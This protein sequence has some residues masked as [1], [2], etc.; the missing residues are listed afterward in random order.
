MPTTPLDEVDVFCTGGS[1]T[2]FV[3]SKLVTGYTGAENDP[4]F[5][6][7][8]NEYFNQLSA[9]IRQHAEIVNNEIIPNNDL[10]QDVKELAER[11]EF[12]TMVVF[13]YFGT[14]IPSGW[15]AFQGQVFD[16]TQAPKLFAANGNSNV[17]P[18]CR[19]NALYGAELLTGVKVYSLGEVKGHSHDPGTLSIDPVGNH[20]H[21]L[22]TASSGGSG[23]NGR[24]LGGGAGASTGGAGG[25]THTVSGGTGESGGPI[26]NIP[27]HVTCNF[28]TRFE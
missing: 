15:I 28:I 2:A 6:E 20:S 14:V 5:A 24:I 1:K 21:G 7:N 8:I 12:P 18:D 16:Q 13:P 11:N 26:G 27:R 19:E 17:L 25:H 10:F 23:D 9:A 22:Q 3:P 4:A